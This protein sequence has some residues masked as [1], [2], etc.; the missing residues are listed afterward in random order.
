MML[1]ANVRSQRSHS[2][3]RVGFIALMLCLASW[4][5]ALAA[6]SDAQPVRI[7]DRFDAPETWT[8]AMSDEVRAS[9]HPA[10]GPSG[11]ALRLDFDLGGTAGYAAARRA[12]PVDLPPNYELSFYLRADAPV[13]EL[14]VKLV[15]ASGDNVWWF[16]RPDFEFPRDWR[17]IRIKKRQIDFAWGPTSD[18]TL[19]HAATIELVV[20]AG[21]GGGRGS[22]YLSEL[23][24]RELPPI[25]A[26]R[27]ARVRAGRRSRDGVDERPRDRQGTEPDRRSRP[28][29]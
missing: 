5:A 28:G 8:A 21:R 18:R 17:L 4:S 2:A 22:V 27:R 24:L 13:N 25:A 16:H 15:D 6:Q 26:R 29:A 12:L 23:A 3:E 9:V 7:L 1:F 14:Q 11:P 10:A 20:N 19:R